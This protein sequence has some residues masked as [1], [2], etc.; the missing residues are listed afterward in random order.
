ML[1]TSFLPYTLLLP[2]LGSDLVYVYLCCVT[3]SSLLNVSEPQFSS[4]SGLYMDMYHWC[5]KY[6]HKRGRLPVDGVLGSKGSV[7]H[8]SVQ[9][10]QFLGGGA[11]STLQFIFCKQAKT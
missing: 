2:S 8:S 1:D 7:L 6:P 9:G 4:P 11:Q 3:M 5:V 10:G